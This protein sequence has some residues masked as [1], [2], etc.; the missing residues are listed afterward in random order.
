MYS[1]VLVRLTVGNLCPE[2]IIR[3]DTQ[4]ARAKSTILREG[5]DDSDIVQK[6]LH[7]ARQYTAKDKECLL[8]SCPQ[9]VE[10]IDPYT[11]V[12]RALEPAPYVYHTRRQG[13]R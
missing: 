13:T 6:F 4:H 10:A 3:L 9:R 12:P 8:L 2:D 11:G 7:K 5:D 1:G